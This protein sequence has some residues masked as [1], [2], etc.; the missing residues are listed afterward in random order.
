MLPSVASLKALRQLAGTSK[1]RKAYLGIGN[2]LLEGAQ[3]DPLYGEINRL[4]AQ[5]ARDKQKCQGPTR[6]RVA[7]ESGRALGG[8][9]GLFHGKNADIEQIRLATPLPETADELCDV[10]R[11]L[12]ASDSEILLG[13][14]ASEGAMKDL[15]ADG[16]LAEYRFL[17]FATHGAV[18][19]EVK[20]A[21]EPGLILTPPERGTTDIKALERDDGYLTA[22]EIASLRLDSD[23]VI[24]SACNT[25]SGANAKAEALSGL[26]RAFFYA[27]ARSL[28]VSHWEVDS[29]ATVKLVTGAFSAFTD[30]PHLTHGE[31]LQRSMLALVRSGGQ[32]AH[33]SYWAPFIVVG[34]GGEGQPSM[35]DAT[36]VAPDLNPPLPGRAVPAKASASKERPAGSVQPSLKKKPSAAS[37]APASNW[38]RDVFSR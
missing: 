12:G 31:A 28:L 9:E 2:P 22:S 30:N 33:P 6:T 20:D 17:H 24:L 14:R 3:Q 19:G 23:W 29:D 36:A 5:A 15:S 7:F 26:A 1:A 32:D 11:Q 27:G 18:A 10:G 38:E 34:A 21:A 35:T 37:K 25:A 13:D 8:F 16:R 4:R